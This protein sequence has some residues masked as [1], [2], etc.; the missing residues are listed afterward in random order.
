MKCT[1]C[2][3]KL[4]EG[5][6]FCPKCGKE[7]QWV[8]EY[9]T[10]ETL[11]KQRELKE[12]EKRKKELE[13]QKE[14]ER[15]QRKAELERKKKKKRRIILAGSLTAVVAAAGLGMFFVYQSQHNSF[16]FQMAQAETKFSNKDYE[17]ALKYIE[18]ALSLNPKSAEA[19]VLEA[20][21]YLK[22]DNESAALS[23]LLS[24]VEEHPDSVNA[25]GELLRLYEKNEEFDKIAELM[26][27]ASDTMKEKYKAYVSEKPLPSNVG[28]TYSIDITVE[29]QN[30][31]EGTEVFYTLNGKTP[32]RHSKKYEEAIALE[33]EETVTLKYIAYNQKGIPSEVGEETY[34]LTFKAPDKPQISPSS[35]KYDYAAEIIV[36]A[37]EDCEIYYA[38]DEEPTVDSQKYTGPITMPEGEHT[39]SAIAVDKRG[40]VSPV[41]SAIY[42]YYG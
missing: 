12:L 29:F 38:F 33:E 26:S 3:A 39:F 25:Y 7:V 8:P 30:L 37:A 42:V 13:L 15:L 21:I 27:N 2:G 23:I 10:L 1:K 22:E 5:T 18:R 20:K 19:N 40:K 35:D 16:D 36:T 4:E 14:Q 41:S 9:N 34:T 32:D 11:I 17:S 6:L 24:V 28:G 31:P